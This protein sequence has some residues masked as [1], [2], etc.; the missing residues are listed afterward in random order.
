MFSTF[1]HKFVAAVVAGWLALTVLALGVQLLER[2]QLARNVAASSLAAQL[3]ESLQT[4]FQ[5]PHNKH[6]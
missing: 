1:Q 5:P 6:D 2:G 4:F 3:D